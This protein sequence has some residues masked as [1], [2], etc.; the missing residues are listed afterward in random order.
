MNTTLQLMSVAML[1]A[2]PSSVDSKP[3]ASEV[4]LQRCIV[5]LIKDVQIPARQAG[6][7]KSLALEDGT[8]VQ[9]GLAVKTGQS[10][11]L[12]DDDD[13][14][15]RRRAAQMEH[16]VAKA[17][18]KKAEAS[19]AAA[20]ATVKV[21]EAEVD[22]SKEINLRTA[23]A[24]PETQVRRQ[25]LTVDRAKSEAEVAAR[26][27]ETA[28]LTID[29]KDAQLEVATITLNQHA[30]EAPQDGIIVQMYRRVGEWVSP[31]DPIMRLVY[32]EKLRVEG[33]V[34]ADSYTSDEIFGREIEVTVH[35]P[36]G[37]VEK[38]RSTISFV[39]PVI[40]SS[41]EYRVWC[42]VENREHKA[43]WILRPGMYADMTI[44]L[45]A[46]P[47]KVAAK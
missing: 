43:H 19:I 20:D 8:P 42:D 23:R 6:V 12:L 16:S 30:I 7:L 10:L 21:A 5:S 36:H 41:G 38:F 44:N 11:G 35:L 2:P 46:P 34:N 25:V 22:E 3:G 17:G 24:I 27:V 39:D 4:K 18:L 9:E 37:R 28:E 45:A 32:M 15:A 33:F 40:D 29:A 26:E 1:M 31:G 13:A 14:R 47:A